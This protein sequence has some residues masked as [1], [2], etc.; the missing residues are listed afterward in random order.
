MPHH[1]GAVDHRKHLE[2]AMSKPIT[3]RMW[4][5]VGN[6]YRD[7]HE[8]SHSEKSA[9]GRQCAA[10]MGAALNERFSQNEAMYQKVGK[11]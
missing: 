5:P 1:C 7:W 10:R 9:F 11:S 6:G 8:L 2:E 4:V 3:Y